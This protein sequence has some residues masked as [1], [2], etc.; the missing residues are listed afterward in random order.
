MTQNTST[1][2]MARRSEPH[3]SLD[4]FPTPPWATRALLAFLMAQGFKIPGQSCWEPCANRGFMVR[5]LAEAF[6]VVYG[7]DAHDYGHGYAVRDFLFPGDEP[8][9]DWIITNPPFRLAQEVALTAI[10]RARV[11]VALLLRSVWTEGGERYERIF[12]NRAPT[13]QLQF[14]HR[15]PMVKGRVDENAVSATAYSWFIWDVRGGRFFNETTTLCWVP[16]GSRKV[17]E[18]AGDYETTKFAEA[19]E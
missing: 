8:E 14:S 7:S 13:Y 16:P 10:E 4:D 6:E 9:F 2:V 17:L 12:K 5:P 1:A 3:D 15:V 18:M 19:A 11:G